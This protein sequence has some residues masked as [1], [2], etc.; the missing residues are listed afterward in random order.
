[1]T[2]IVIPA[3][4]VIPAKAG[5]PESN[6]THDTLLNGRITLTQLKIGHRVGTDAVL[7]A[8]AAPALK[9][10]R[11]IDIGAGVG[12]VGLMLATLHETWHGVLLEQDENLCQLATDNIKANQLTA[13]LTVHHA[14]IFAKPCA[15][16]KL[17]QADLI[18]TNPP[19]FCAPHVRCSPDSARAKAHV[20]VEPDHTLGLWVSTT[21]TLLKSGGTFV[22][23]MPPAA[24]PEVLASVTP[25]LGALTLLP[26]LPKAGASAH[27][28]LLRGMKGSKAPLSIAPPLVLHE[29]D[30]AFT[31][32]ANALHAGEDLL[33]WE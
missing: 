13:R 7:L 14:D 24:L 21:L 6:F 22:M 2:N 4:T 32:E 12:A 16:Q 33:R 18:I 15:G 1:M 31:P 29:A 11:F 17:P 8:K 26:I 3:G 27:R 9:Q 23:I 19:F 30:G 10:A 25:K 20:F 5:I 28:L